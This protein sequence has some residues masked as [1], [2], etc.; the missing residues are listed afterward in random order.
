LEI[1]RVTHSL[2]MRNL[3]MSKGFDTPIGGTHL[4]D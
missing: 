3:L 2:S 1:T 4:A